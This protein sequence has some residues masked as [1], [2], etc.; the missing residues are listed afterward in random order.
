MGKVWRYV[1]FD[2]SN[3]GF[4]NYLDIPEIWVAVAALKV[5]ETIVYQNLQKFRSSIDF[6]EDKPNDYAFLLF[7][8]SDKLIIP[9]EK[10]LGII[11]ASLLNHEQINNILDV[12]IDGIWESNEKEF[13]QEIISDVTKLTKE[14]VK[15]L[16]G[17]GLDS[18]IKI[19]NYA[20]IRAYWL[21]S[22]KS[23]EELSNN[24]HRKELLRDYA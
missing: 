3:R 6:I 9:K 23:L 4:N 19:V 5:D 11:L 1:G 20:D 24:N 2:E 21:F 15:I 13:T 8:R 7:S 12:Y 22:K 17:K 16:D 18:K 10:K 14:N